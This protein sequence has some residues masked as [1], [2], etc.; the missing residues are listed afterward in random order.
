MINELPISEL[1]LSRRYQRKVTGKDYVKV[2]SLLMLYRGYSVEAVS[3]RLGI[4]VS[5]VYR[6]WNFYKSNGLDSFLENRYKDYWG[7]L[8]SSE[9]SLLRHEL[10]RILYTDA[11]SV[12]KWIRDTFGVDYTPQGTVDLLNRIG[13]IYK[14]TKEVLC[15][16]SD[17]KQLAFMEKLSEVIMDFDEETVVYYA[18]GVHPT[19]NS[20]STYAWIEKGEDFEQPTVSGRDR[21]NINELVNAKDVT[22][23]IYVDCENVNAQ[24]TKE[25]YQKALEKHPEAKKIYILSDNA[26][27]YRNKELTE[28]IQKTAITQIFLPPYSPNLNLIERLWRFLRKKVINTHFYRTKELFRKAIHVFFDD[29]GQYKSELE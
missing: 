10:K 6:Y 4:D 14:K 29:I 20:R 27:Y 7:L 25:L 13:F 26:R 18:D 11:K 16:C 5:T 8:S 21:I 23:V 1:E 2:T 19:H 3:D 17:E 12:S 22:D 24:S 28:W 15:E 9:L